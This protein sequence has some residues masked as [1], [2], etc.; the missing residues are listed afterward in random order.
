MNILDE[1]LDFMGMIKIKKNDS[2]SIR[3]GLDE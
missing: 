1:L 3:S 2:C